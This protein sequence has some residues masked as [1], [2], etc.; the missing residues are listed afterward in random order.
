MFK[1]LFA[2]DKNSKHSFFLFGPRGTGK[3]TWLKANFPEEIYLDLLDSELS[4]ALMSKPENLE[5]YIPSDYRGWVILDE[6]QKIPSLLNEVHRLIEGKKYKFILSGSSARGLRRAGVNLLAGRALTYYFHPL[7]SEELA[8]HFSLEK[9]LKFG[10]LPMVYNTQDPKKFLNSY[11]QAYLKEEIQQEGLTR[12]LG[13]FSRFLETASFSQGEVLNISQ[14]AKEA[15]LERKTVENYFKILEDLL[16]AER[17]PVFNKR[18]KRKLIS[19]NKFYFFDTGV[20]RALR[21]SGPLDSNEEIDGPAL[22][23]LFL[24]ELRALNDYYDLD[25]KIYYWRSVAKLEVDFV[26][27]GPKIFQAIEIKRKSV[28]TDNDLRGLRAF[29]A[30]YPEA[31]CYLFCMAK[32]I[33]YRGNITIIPIKKAFS[34]WG[35]FFDYSS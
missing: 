21:P 12:N 25:F 8:G 13:D 16:I 19:H 24:Q 5:N 28:I 18:A 17:L 27:Y 34:N 1:R 15:M 4:R 31:K 33:E 7:T 30:D 14:V 29:S 3:T 22:E 35:K 9:S 26:L 10:H 32:N 23:T 11:I 6:V 20:F 2:I